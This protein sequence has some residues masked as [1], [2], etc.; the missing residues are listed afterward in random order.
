MSRQVRP[1]SAGHLVPA[2]ACPSTRCSRHGP[3]E[4]SAFET[5]SRQVLRRPIVLVPN[6][7]RWPLPVGMRFGEALQ[8]FQHLVP[9]LRTDEGRASAGSGRTEN[10]S[11]RR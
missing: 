11:A 5:L 6:P 9:A 3:V 10:G 2:A 1:G 8:P 7:V 4:N